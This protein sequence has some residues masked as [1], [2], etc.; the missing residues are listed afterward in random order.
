MF[1]WTPGSEPWN[2]L[3]YG[4]ALSKFYWCYALLQG[5]IYNKMNHTL[6]DVLYNNTEKGRR[7][8]A[9]IM[10]HKIEL[11][12][13]VLFFTSFAHWLMVKEFFFSYFVLVYENKLFRYDFYGRESACEYWVNTF[14]WCTVQ[15]DR[16]L[17]F[18]KVS[19]VVCQ[20]C[21]NEQE[22]MGNELGWSFAWRWNF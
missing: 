12:W 22:W 1:I 20:F 9:L 15:W 19:V 2:K 10:Q 7:A 17:F 18:Y 21:V 8:I 5:G 3:T 4:L 14:Q 6:H 16:T 13:L 11:L